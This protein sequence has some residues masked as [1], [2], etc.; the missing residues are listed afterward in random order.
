MASSAQ[1]AAASRN[2]YLAPRYLFWV[3]LAIRLGWITL[4]HT[5]RFAPYTDHFSFGWEAG[6]IARALATGYG[7]ADPFLGHTGPTAWLAPGYPLLMAAI[8]RLFGVFTPLAGWM[9]L[10]CG[11]VAN[12]AVAPLAWEIG[13]RSFSLKVARWAAWIW[14][15]LPSAMQYAVRFP[16]ETAIS[17][18]L[19][20]WLLA[21][22]LRMRF[23]A[24]TW[25]RWAGFGGL[26]GAIALM[27]PALLIFLPFAGCWLLI[28]RMPQGLKP[29]FLRGP[30]A[31]VKAFAYLQAKATPGDDEWATQKRLAGAFLAATV[32][33]AMLLPWW[34]RNQRVMHAFI[35]VRSNAGVEA[36]LGNCY[37]IPGSLMEWE[38]P[39]LDPAEL[40]AY[41]E[42]GELQYS[43]DKMA[44][45]KRAIVARPGLFAAMCLL[46]MDYFWFAVPHGMD[47]PVRDLTRKLGFSFVSV[48]G[49]LGG[50]LAW[51]RRR[52]GAALFL[53][54]LLSVPFPYY[55]VIVWARFR[56]PLEPLITVLAVY[57][58]QS[59]EKNWRVYWRNPV[60]PARGIA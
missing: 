13:A 47:R 18:F 20:T 23:D 57:L 19:F 45:A 55:L 26:W 7:Y 35:P 21:L 2:P 46:R 41:R 24:M 28:S 50:I 44:Q 10:A 17:A 15:L 8:F 1:S 60:D 36:C 4:G 6:H 9:V 22:V 51:R 59:A 25:P 34:I 32:C 5:Y 11:A 48:A 31:E 3:A 39:F 12:A 38:H 42:R 43:A 30:N 54:A 27:N 49:I 33:V 29:P 58:F 40:Q 53:L 52:P 56:H 14:V 37:G 16:W